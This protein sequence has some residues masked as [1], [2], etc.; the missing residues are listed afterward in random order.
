MPLFEQKKMPRLLRLRPLPER[1]RKPDRTRLY[2]TKNVGHAGGL[3]SEKRRTPSMEKRLSRLVDSDRPA[4]ATKMAAGKVGS[5][6]ANRRH[7]GQTAM[8]KADAGGGRRRTESA[9]G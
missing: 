1:R 7:G 3:A 2:F 4:N 8:M 6:V 5:R 9:K